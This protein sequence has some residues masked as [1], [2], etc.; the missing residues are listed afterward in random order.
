M[1]LVTGGTGLVGAHLMYFLLNENRIVRA[2]H[3]KDSDL[4]SVKKVFS[5]YT[6]NIDSLFNKIDWVEADILDIP[7]L[8]MAFDNVTHVFHCA[9]YINFNPAKYQKLKKINIEG[10]A[11]IV[12]LCLAKKVIKLCYVSSVATFGN[13]LK[14]KP[15]NE[16]NGW[17]PDEK[18][19]IYSIT[20]YGAEM[21]V[22]RGTQEGLDAVI[23]NPGIIFGISPNNGGSG[24]ISKLV[25]RRINY[26]PPGGMG[27]VDVQDVVKAMILLMD[28]NII[29][30][31]YIL[32]GENV[33]YKDILDQM[34]KLN[35]KKPP[36][37]K[38]SRGFLYFL[39]GM[40][41]LSSKL[42]GTQ[43]RLV[44]STVR[45]MFSTPIYDSSKIKKALN[46]EFTPTKKTLERVVEN[47]R[48]SN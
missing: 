15:I 26:Y 28:S 46:F 23:V 44:K 22:W 2:I 7:A 16:E 5:T 39:S 29:N 33:S 3:R 13:T 35:D 30:Q 1:I 41:W 21:E 38:L 24:I 47:E 14:N 19:S 34:A 48:K 20:K 40:D 37:K 4:N 17:N 10:T 27:I 9:A 36:S 8:T 6:S 11:N 43:R 32:I 25:T 45:S 18:N 12:N 31:Q 42:F